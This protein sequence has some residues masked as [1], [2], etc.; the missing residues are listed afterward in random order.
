MKKLTIAICEDNLDI[1]EELYTIIKNYNLYQNI[2]ANIYLYK[3]GKTFLREC[4]TKEFTFVFMDIDLGDMNG[5]TVVNEFRKKVSDSVEIVFITSFEQYKMQVFSLHIFDYIVKPFDSSTINKVLDE[6]M[7][8]NKAEKKIDKLTLKTTKG[9]IH[10]PVYEIMYFEF[11]SRKIKITCY[12]NE[13]YMNGTMRELK[14]ELSKYSFASPHVAFIV[15]LCEV[16]EFNTN[17][18]LIMTNDDIVPISQPRLKSF[19]S[20]Y[21]EYLDSKI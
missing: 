4:E 1:Q 17:K 10:I 20:L 15:N 14:G 9:I 21:F 13:Y 11:V 5:V 6:L 16:R 7:L 19:R 3:N 8:W 2:N 18:T 12:K